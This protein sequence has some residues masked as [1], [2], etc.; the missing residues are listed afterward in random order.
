VADW[1]DNQIRD[2]PLDLSWGKVALHLQ[3]LHLE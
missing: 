3:V 2:G 1:L